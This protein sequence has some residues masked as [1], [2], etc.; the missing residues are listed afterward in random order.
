MP[1]SVNALS[2]HQPPGNDISLSLRKGGQSRG[3][4]ALISK[5]PLPPGDKGA[6]VTA[7]LMKPDFRS[8]GRLFFYDGDADHFPCF[9]RF[10][11]VT[12]RVEKRLVKLQR[13]GGH[14]YGYDSKRK[15]SKVVL[16][17]TVG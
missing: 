4:G 2:L 6:G 12:D 14:V 11:S 10:G 9:H 7:P 15:F 1:S 5:R 17:E 16:L 8:I 3:S 13:I